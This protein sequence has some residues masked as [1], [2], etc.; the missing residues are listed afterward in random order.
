MDQITSPEPN[1][2]ILIA[3]GVCRAL[4][5]LG[6]SCLTEFTTKERLRMDVLALGRKGE[7]WCVEV[8]SCRADF[9]SDAKWQGY[10][11]WCDRFFFAVPESFPTEL[12]PAGHGLILADRFGGE[13]V[14]PAPDATLAPARRK[15]MTLQFA[16]V[17]ADR[18]LRSADEQPRSPVF[19]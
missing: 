15:A 3:R 11:G 18:L 7:L 17:A 4:S 8:K 12:L 9:Q 16:R 14:R 5:E 1:P 6:F 10:L 13:I 19:A 2:G